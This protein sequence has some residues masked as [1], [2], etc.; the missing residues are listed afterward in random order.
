MRKC[1]ISLLLVLAT[2]LGSAPL[3]GQTAGS[4]AA[5]DSTAFAPQVSWPATGLT[6]TYTNGTVYLGGA[7]NSITGGTLTM[8]TNETT[9]AGPAYSAC[10][11]VY[12]PAS[13]TALSVTTTYAT[14]A[15]YGNR[16]L[17][18]VTTSSA[19]NIT[20]ASYANL[21]SGGVIPAA[22]NDQLFVIPPSSCWMSVSGT[23][24]STAPA[25]TRVAANNQVLSGVLS[26]TA[27]TVYIDCDFSFEGRTTSGLGFQITSVSL[28]YGIQGAAMSSIAAAT[29]TTIT[30]PVA[31]GAASG[32]V[33]AVGGTLTVSPTSPQ[34]G[35]TTAGQC[36]NE[37]IA[38]GTPFTMSNLTR[39]TL[40]QGMS[41]STTATTLQVCGM[42]V[43][44]KW[45]Q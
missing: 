21:D 4:A 8:T 31:G 10:N 20:G 44:G 22:Y 16:I 37:N 26:T 42:L 39:F 9:C 24:W 1:L 5:L 45:I 13:G 35:T 17:Y 11:I 6:L 40:E 43:Y 29:P 18:L 14:A 23:T 41:N 7:A 2:V 27:G 30:Y 19:G 28:L 32:T 3:R 25:L 15:A 12:W 38:F 33:A 34:T 36:Y